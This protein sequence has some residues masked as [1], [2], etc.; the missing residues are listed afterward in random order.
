MTITEH[1]GLDYRVSPVE[2]AE[3][4][5]DIKAGDIVPLTPIEVDLQVWTNK[6]N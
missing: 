2:S 4:L 1:N 5:I 6:L 3:G